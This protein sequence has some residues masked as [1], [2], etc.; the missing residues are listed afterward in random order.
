MIEAVVRWKQTAMGDGASCSKALLFHFAL[1]LR[2]ARGGGRDVPVVDELRRDERVHGEGGE[3]REHQHRVAS[4]LHR[5]EDA[6]QGPEEQ[7][8]ARGGGQLAG[9]AVAV[10]GHHLDH[11]ASDDDGQIERLHG[12][13]HVDG[14]DTTEQYVQQRQVD[15]DEGAGPHRGASVQQDERRD[16]GR[17][18]HEEEAVAPSAEGKALDVAVG[19]ARRDGEEVEQDAQYANPFRALAVEDLG[20]LRD[21]HHH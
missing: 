15:E 14:G 1:A 4:L 9:A 17:L 12:P 8:E 16:G 18:Q 19:S 7:H 13:E 10:V 20:D 3:V 11:L 5:G 21:F 6:R 2:F